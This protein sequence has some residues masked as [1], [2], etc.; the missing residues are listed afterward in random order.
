MNIQP[1]LLLS[2][3]LCIVSMTI[4]LWTWHE[5]LNVLNARFDLLRERVLANEDSIYGIRSVVISSLDADIYQLKKEIEDLKRKHEKC[6]KHGGDSSGNGH[7]ASVEGV[8][9]APST[10]KQ[11]CNLKG[12]M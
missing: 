11:V 9:E 1:I 12:N 5:R 7:T 2:L 6:L 10:N 8:L 3:S 4:Y